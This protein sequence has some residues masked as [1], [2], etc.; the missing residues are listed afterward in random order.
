M[1]EPRW[2]INT[3]LT[4]LGSESSICVLEIWFIQIL[5]IRIFF[6]IWNFLVYLKFEIYWN[7]E[8]LFPIFH[9][10]FLHF[11]FLLNIFCNS[12]VFIYE[13]F[14]LQR[15]SLIMIKYW[16]II[17]A[18]IYMPAGQSGLSAFW[19]SNCHIF[20]PYMEASEPK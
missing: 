19:L 5:R 4:H 3:G 20:G 12:Q 13:N 2:L 7:E 16:P 11:Y 8:F 1:S 18:H 9:F 10:S 15:N 17:L 6:E 14:I